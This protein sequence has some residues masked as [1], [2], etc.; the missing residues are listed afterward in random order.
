[1]VPRLS[2]FYLISYIHTIFLLLPIKKYIYISF[3][4]FS[5]IS[6]HSASYCYPLLYHPPGFLYFAQLTWR[7]VYIYI[8][9]SHL[10]SYFIP[11][12][13]FLESLSLQFSS[14]LLFFSFSLFPLFNFPVYFHSPP[15]PLCHCFIPVSASF[16]I[17]SGNA[18]ISLIILF[19][20]LF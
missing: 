7:Y 20:S 8:F 12:F 19:L 18:I 6:S 10:F 13:L 16:T 3:S 9:F 11:L 1:M 5:S 15:S 14:F 4:S 17:N 2:F